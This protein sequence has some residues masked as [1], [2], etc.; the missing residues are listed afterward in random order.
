MR[1]LRIVAVALCLAAVGTAALLTLG[2]CGGTHAASVGAGRQGP[3][4][5]G[6]WFALA[7][8]TQL[9]NL[10]GTVKCTAIA[11]A[12]LL[13]TSGTV[14]RTATISRGTARFP[15]PPLPPGDYFI[16]VNHASANL[17]PTRI[18]A[19]GG[20]VIQFVGWKLRRTVIGSLTA[21]SLRFD[22]FSEGQKEH[23][24][25]SYSTGTS[26]SPTRYAYVVETLVPAPQ[27]IEI[28]VLGSAAL[29]TSCTA[30][31]SHSNFADRML[32][33]NNHG[34]HASACGRCHGRLGSKAVHYANISKHYGFCYKCHYGEAGPRA[35][36]LDPAR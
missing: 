16:R 30:S 3:P 27:K 8:S 23:A 2:G 19:P 4:P 9:D 29:L 31:G 22:T 34:M 6:A 26:L 13:D 1:N 18:V 35:G 20:P 5:G 11:K 32:G 24:V 14:L 17:V 28:R 12:E 10:P 7:L 15:D 25:V 36:M 33:P 21:P